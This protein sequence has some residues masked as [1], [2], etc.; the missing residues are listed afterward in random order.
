MVI[1][2]MI[3]AFVVFVVAT[4]LL[5]NTRL[6]GTRDTA[7][8]DGADGAKRSAEKKNASHQHREQTGGWT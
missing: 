6:L 7:L 4:I 2:K 3:D 8:L 1:E 5:K